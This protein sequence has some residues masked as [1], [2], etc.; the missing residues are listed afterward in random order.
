MLFSFSCFNTFNVQIL[1]DIA[2]IINISTLVRFGSESFRT[3][4]EWILDVFFGLLEGSDFGGLAERCVRD[5]ERQRRMLRAFCIAIHAGI[6]G[7]QLH[8]DHIHV[9]SH[10][11]VASMTQ[12]RCV[13]ST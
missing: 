8:I 2:I 7:C 13:R 11:T 4:F 9:S 5:P 12:L 1:R 10:D 3:R 6:G